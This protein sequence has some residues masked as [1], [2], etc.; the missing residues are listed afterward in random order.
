MNKENEHHTVLCS[1][2]TVDTNLE[3][4]IGS[5]EFGLSLRYRGIPLPM[6]CYSRMILLFSITEPDAGRVGQQGIELDDA[7]ANVGG[8]QRGCVAHDGGSV[9]VADL[10]RYGVDDERGH[11]KGRR[12][13]HQVREDGHHPFLIWRSRR[14][15]AH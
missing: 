13:E 3:M 1:T 10:R 2:T 11:Q 6:T 15:G 12:N 7:Q 5:K 14:D 4:E 8:G 9:G